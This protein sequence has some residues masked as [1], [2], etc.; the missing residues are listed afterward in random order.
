MKKKLLLTILFLS[1]ISTFVSAYS[2]AQTSQ[3]ALSPTPVPCGGSGCPVT[4]P[5]LNYQ[6]AA[7]YE[8]WKQNP[9]KNFWVEDKEVTSLGKNAERAREFVYWVVN[10]STIYYHPSIFESWKS[11]RNVALALVFLLAALSGIS[12]IVTRRFNFSFKLDVNK[13][14]LKIVGVALYVVFSA[15]LVITI[16]QLTD[17]LMK[18]F[19]ENLNVNNLFNIFFVN[20]SGSILSQ[21]EKAY[22]TFVGCKN[23]SLNAAESLKTSLLL[24]KITNLTYFL[25]GGILLIRRIVLWFLI[26]L[27][28]FLAILLF[29]K[30]S[31]NTGIIWIGTFLQWAFYGP[32]TALFL[33]TVSKIWSI[34]IPFNFNFSRAGTPEGF[35]YPTA[36][37]ILFGGPSQQVSFINS[38]NYIDTFAEYV[39]SI[40]M[41]WVAIILPWLLLRS[42]RDYCCDG[43]MAIKNLL[44]SFYEKQKGSPSPT[45][46]GLKTY[47]KSTIGIKE[48]ATIP[49]EI[50]IQNL[51]EIKKMATEEIAKSM[52]LKIQKLQDVAKLETN[53]EYRE[54]LQKIIASLKQPNQIADPKER[55]K[56]MAIKTELYNRA[57]KKDLLAERILKATTTSIL[58][59][60]ALKKQVVEQIPKPT[61]TQAFISTAVKV[62]SQTINKVLNLLPSLIT[63]KS[64]FLNSI[65]QTVNLSPQH[66]SQIVNTFV[67]NLSQPITKVI[68]KIHE[69]TGIEKEKIKEVLK[70]FYNTLLESDSVIEKISQ[71]TNLPADKVEQIIAEGLSQAIEVEENIEKAIPVP[72]TISIEEYENTKK[73]WKDHYLKGEVPLSEN[74]TS[75]KEWVEQDIVYITNL[76]NKLLSD[77]EKLK[78]EALEDLSYILPVFIINDMSPQELIVYLKAKLE[79]AKEVKEE[80][81]KEERLK[82]KLRKEIK[83]EEE[84][85]EIPLKKTKDKSESKVLRAQLPEENDQNEN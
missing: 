83:E 29:F 78:E 39:I 18:L 31:K 1:V 16:I 47:L 20:P 11:A 62:P 82:E 21:S 51:E 46:P 24:I 38:S 6:C 77:D 56:L 41:L 72:P 30:P 3:Q 43:I 84:L 40:L 81:E 32:L 34:G 25:I 9:Y 52:Q 14:I 79:A 64:S 85:V 35:V 57:R 58:E 27:S 49:V 10:R 55:Q 22:K 80:L 48:K 63:Q 74:I 68:E 65:A 19:V 4:P 67:T 26:I 12:I 45:L 50:K 5:E 36:V 70:T 69:A 13:V 73:L 17:L 59:T 42:F 7:S 28:P 37:S 60:Q 75:R 53:R 54:Q 15:T 66:T 33:G 2:F 8:D 71:E 76:L 23:L 44:L 61:S